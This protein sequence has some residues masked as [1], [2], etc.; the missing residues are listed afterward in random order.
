MHEISHYRL[1]VRVRVRVPSTTSLRT[2]HPMG[3]RSGFRRKLFAVF[4]NLQSYAYCQ[5]QQKCSPATVLVISVMGLFIRVTSSCI[6]V[7]TN[8]AVTVFNLLFTLHTFYD[9]CNASR[10]GFVYGGAL[11][12][13]IVLYCIVRGS[14]KPVDCIHSADFALTVVTHAVH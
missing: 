1:R 8:C 7:L 10:S 12:T 2:R 6:S 9:Y 11:N 4:G 13:L 5:R 3:W 14:V